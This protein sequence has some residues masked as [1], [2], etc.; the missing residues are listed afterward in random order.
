[1]TDALEL[2]PGQFDNIIRSSYNNGHQLFRIILRRL[3]DSKKEMSTK[4]VYRA[5]NAATQAL[6]SMGSSQNCNLLGEK[7]NI[8]L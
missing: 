1:V 3:C 7:L 4:R 2:E 5:S 6:E 8:K